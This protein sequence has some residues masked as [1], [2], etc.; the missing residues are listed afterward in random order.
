MQQHLLDVMNKDLSRLS[1]QSRFVKMI[2]DG[3]L[4]VS[5]KKKSVL[6]DELRKL[7]F[8]PFPKKADAKKA[9]E[10]EAFVEEAEGENENEEEDGG[11]ARD[12]DYLLGMAIWSLTQE[13]VDK[14]LKQIGDKELEIDALIK[15]SPKDLWTKDLDDFINEWRDQLEEE[16]TRAKKSRSAGRRASAKLGLGGKPAKRK[17]KGA[18]SEDDED[19]TVGKKK[20]P[21]V[22]SVLDR[23]KA[24]QPSAL[25]SY[26]APPQAPK[27]T[28]ST[29]SASIVPKME[30]DDFMDIDDILSDSK[31]GASVPALV[32]AVKKGGRATAAKAK[33]APKKAAAPPPA[34]APKAEL[35]DVDDVFEAVAQQA[36][37]KTAEPAGRQRRAAAQTKKYALS[38]DSEDSNGDDLLGD[39]SMMV[40][41]IG[42]SSGDQSATEARPLFSNT[43]ARPGSGHGLPRSISKKLT[44]IMDESDGIDETDYKSLIP[45]GSPV[46]PAARRANE[47]ID[48]DDADDDAEESFDMPAPKTK[49][50]PKKAS[51]TTVAATA[52]PL[53]KTKVTKSAPAP[54]K[55]VPLSPAAKAYAAKQAK[56]QASMADTT[57]AASRPAP[58]KPA[59]KPK[60]AAVAAAA[61]KKVVV[62]SDDDD[63]LLANEILSD[64]DDDEPIEPIVR[65]RPGRRTVVAT[66]KKA[67]KYVFSDE[68]EEEEEEE[69]ESFLVDDESD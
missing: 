21:A 54:K 8:N 40:K 11:S 61:A 36:A 42:T 22:K 34:P 3:K 25:T 2:I 65:A 45:V 6:V 30:D 5:K 13:R 46:R 20:K 66:A 60:A 44:D 69:E 50:L 19:F 28:E 23:V 48:L 57:A 56:A 39:V 18:D 38:S 9:G 10:K 16:K 49:M 43:T 47:V 12:Y 63:E 41:G 26:F 33:P 58:K 31:A 62:I 37:R 52:K 51:R 7:G 4:V 29:A 1:N 27:A 64:G 35:S 67:A 17:R 24:K 53:A 59:A 68:S 55:L 14:L 32:V 15:L